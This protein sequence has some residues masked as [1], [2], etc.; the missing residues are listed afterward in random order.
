MGG[1][2]DVR[3]EPGKSIWSGS[4]RSERI[5]AV[6]PDVG[7]ICDGG[8]SCLCKGKTPVHTNSHQKLGIGNEVM[9]L[10][11]ASGKGDPYLSCR[12]ADMQLPGNLRKG[13]RFLD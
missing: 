6:S 8:E 13:V 11:P 2:C 9:F 10:Q 1:G 5:L 7:G 3:C 12:R 4:G